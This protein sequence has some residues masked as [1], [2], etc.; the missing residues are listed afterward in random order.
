MLREL[1]TTSLVLALAGCS[2]VRP[3]QPSE[4]IPRKNPPMVWVEVKQGPVQALNHP[5]IKG[6]TL[7]GVWE[8]TQEEVAL[9]LNDVE[10]VRVK[11]FDTGRT[12]ALVAIGGAA[13]A[14]AA[15]FASQAGEA[16]YCPTNVC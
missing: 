14:I 5:Q 13:V 2:S 9:P 6:D 11:Q 7:K 16:Q 15:Y 12:V 10:S 8:N 3:V 1:K 4:F